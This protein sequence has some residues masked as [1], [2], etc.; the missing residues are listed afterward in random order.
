METVVVETL[1]RTI[2]EQAANIYQL[3]YISGV[4]SWHQE[5]RDLCLHLS[6]TLKQKVV[7]RLPSKH[8]TDPGLRL[9]DEIKYL[10]ETSQLKFTLTV[11][12]AADTSKIST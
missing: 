1:H 5:T 4:A 11:P 10:K 7:P 6:E 12:D 3:I 9:R 2:P 8:V